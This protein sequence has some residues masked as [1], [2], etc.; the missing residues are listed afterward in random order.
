MRLTVNLDQQAYGLA[1]NIAREKD[2]SLSEVI[3]GLIKKSCLQNPMEDKQENLRHPLSGFPVSAG[4]RII[5]S[6][7][8][9]HAQLEDDLA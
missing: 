5:T 9:R 7:D 2:C 3:N 6:E 8:V 4:D 1:K